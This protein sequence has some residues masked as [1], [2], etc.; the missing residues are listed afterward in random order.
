MKQR[1]PASQ[2][3]HQQQQQK[4][5]RTYARNEQWT[6]HRGV[7]RDNQKLIRIWSRYQHAA[8]SRIATLETDRRQAERRKEKRR[9]QMKNNRRNEP[10]HACL[11]GNAAETQHSSRWG[12]HAR[13][14]DAMQYAMR[15]NGRCP[16]GINK[17]SDRTA[18][19]VK[20]RKRKLAEGVTNNLRDFIDRT[21]KCDSS[22][23]RLKRRLPIG[24][25]IHIRC[26]WTHRLVGHLSKAQECSPPGQSENTTSKTKLLRW[27]VCV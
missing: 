14:M 8:T 10:N 22:L 16:N 21:E 25:I 2:H 9:K 15:W 11:H 3:R 24:T 27:C 4:Q 6:R 18:L 5:A 13:G 7:T 23:Q 19:S 26:C 17:A 1:P 12:C 20:I